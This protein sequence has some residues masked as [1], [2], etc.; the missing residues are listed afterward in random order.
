VPVGIV[1]RDGPGDS[2]RRPS[3]DRNSP[4]GGSAFGD[5]RARRRGPVSDRRLPLSP[6]GPVLENAPT[7]GPRSIPL[8]GGI[9][10]FTPIGNPAPTDCAVSAA[11]PS[12][13]CHTPLARVLAPGRAPVDDEGPA[14]RSPI[15]HLRRHRPEWHGTPSP[16]CVV[17]V[18]KQSMFCGNCGSGTWW[19]A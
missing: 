3:A 9:A 5:G 10:D 11:P 16:L 12:T 14:P 1:S 15:D 7:R 2:Q 13:P 6:T 19:L 4:A 18:R 17:K 8:P